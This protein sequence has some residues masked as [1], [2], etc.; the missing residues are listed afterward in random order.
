MRRKL[1]A[2]LVAVAV[3]GVAASAGAGVFDLET[4]QRMALDESPSL[5]AAEARIEQAQARVRQARSAYVPRLDVSGS[6]TKIWLSDSDIGG[7]NPLL[8]QLGQS[9]GSSLGTLGGTSGGYSGLGG[10]SGTS[11]VQGL[12]PDKFSYYDLSFAATWTVFDGFAREFTNAAARFGARE[13]EAA[14]QE[15]KRLLLNAVATGYYSALLALEQIDIAEADEAFNLRLLKEAK[16]RRRVGAGSL[17]DE[18]NFEVRANAARTVL[19]Q[20]RQN[21]DVALIGLAALVG[22]P[23]A[24]FADVV[25][26]ARLEPESTGD[27]VSPDAETLIK[28]ARAQRPD[29][30]LGRY[31][32]ERAKTGVGVGRAAFLPTVSAQAVHS[33]SDENEQFHRDEF[34]T[35]VGVTVSYNLFSG[36]LRRARLA[37]AKAA[38][39][40]AERSLAAAEIEVASDV[41]QAIESLEAS[42]DNLKLQRAN[43]DYVQRNRDLVEKGY[44][45]GQASLVRLNEAQRDLIEARARL[46]LARVSLRQAWHDLRTATGETLELLAE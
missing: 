9:G 22:L 7:M 28:Y 32:V 5:Q 8:L 27:L 34:S 30:A 13:S 14:H 11:S 2:L 41:R 37:E 21:N 6:V 45:A 35:T 24:A 29:V 39:T 3:T 4:L 42:Q 31:A 25:E 40:E 1:S 26:L 12:S 36:G 18:L 17:S 33:A 10:M 46:A 43:A 19:I 15:S 38:L 23:D 16:A 44:A 20:A